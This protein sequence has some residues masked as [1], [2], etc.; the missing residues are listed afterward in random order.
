MRLLPWSGEDGKACYLSTDGE[1]SYLSRLAD[2]LEAVQLGMAED[3]LGFVRKMLE[4]DGPAETELRVIVTRMSEA[5]W[6]VLRIAR[7]RGGRLPQLDD[8]AVSAAAEAAI[9]REIR[10]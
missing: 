1:G 5:L 4:E 9:D 3:L 6:D 2:N 7:S 8:D 10:R